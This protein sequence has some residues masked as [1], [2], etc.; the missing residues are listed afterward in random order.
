MIPLPKIAVVTFTGV[1]DD[2]PQIVATMRYTTVAE[3]TKAEI[4]AD[5]RSH[6]KTALEEALDRLGHFTAL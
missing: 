2:Y 6:A 4:L 3:R 1:L 5:I